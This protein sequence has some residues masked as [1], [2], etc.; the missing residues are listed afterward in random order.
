MSEHGPT[1]PLARLV[2]MAVSI[3]MRNNGTNTSESQ[4]T[5][6]TRTAMGERS[7][8]RH[9]ERLDKEGWVNR[10]RVKRAGGEGNKRHSWFHTVYDAVVPDDVYYLLSER[11][12]EAD[13]TW[14]SN[15]NWKRPKGQP[16][17]VA[18][19]SKR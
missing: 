9:L 1:N 13:R 18:G 6:A 7:V 3:P 17:T 16:A 10:T 11:P 12:W 15:P 4:D 2:L 19:S 8:R 5:I 14:R